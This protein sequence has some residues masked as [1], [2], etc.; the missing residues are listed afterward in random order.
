MVTM[1]VEVN[2]SMILDNPCLNFVNACV[3]SASD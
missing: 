3:Y 1:S 2:A